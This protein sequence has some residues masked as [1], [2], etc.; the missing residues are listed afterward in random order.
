MKIIFLFEPNYSKPQDIVLH[1]I[2]LIQHT[3]FY[4]QTSES[5]QQAN[6]SHYL[7]FFFFSLREEHFV[8]MA[9]ICNPCLSEDETGW[10]THRN[11]HVWLHIHNLSSGEW[12]MFF[13]GNI[14]RFRK[15]Y[16]IPW[17]N[18]RFQICASVFMRS[19][20]C[21]ITTMSLQWVILYEILQFSGCEITH[22]DLLHLLLS[23]LKKIPDKYLM[24][25]HLLLQLQFLQKV[26][27][28]NHS[29]ISVQVG[30]VVWLRMDG[31]TDRH[32]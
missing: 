15:T 1:K 24:R 21:C 23:I 9:M 3:E 29:R 28:T 2:S 32:T 31:R 22:L 12:R 6:F 13:F 25:Y 10:Y 26:T 27:F 11:V 20:L 8:I 17:K 16:S 14:L 7:F 5:L 19:E 18:F 4:Y 30:Y